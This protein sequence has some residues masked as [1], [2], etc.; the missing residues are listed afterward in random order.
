MNAFQLA[1]TNF[2]EGYREGAAEKTDLSQVFQKPSGGDGP[3]SQRSGGTASVLHH[4]Q[5]SP[6]SQ[7]P[8]HLQPDKLSSPGTPEE[9]DFSRAPEEAAPSRSDSTIPYQQQGLDAALPDSLAGEVDQGPA[10]TSHHQARADSKSEGSALKENARDDASE[11]AGN[12]MDSTSHSEGFAASVE[13]MEQNSLRSSPLHEGQNPAAAKQ[14]QS[15]GQEP[16]SSDLGKHPGRKG[17]SPHVMVALDRAEDL[18]RALLQPGGVTE[19]RRKELEAAI[20]EAEA[21]MSQE[22]GKLDN[23]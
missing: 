15:V 14:V 1:I 19:E 3:L 6:S 21:A 10:G 13:S 22:A 5:S 7:S 20:S 4:Q 23:K 8:A 11:S 12:Y 18:A 16:V 2:V 9:T 17:E